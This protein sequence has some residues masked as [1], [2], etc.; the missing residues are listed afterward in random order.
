MPSLTPAQAALFEAASCAV[1]TTLRADGSPHSTVIWV[2][3]DG[4]AVSF[5]TLAGRA[6]QRHLADD[7]LLS[8]TIVK[9][10]YVWVTVSGR[11]TLSRDGAEQQLDRLAQ[12][13]LGEATYPWRGE[14]DERVTVTVAIERVDSFGL[15]E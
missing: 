8:I 12:K 9:E 4:E 11:A 1:L 6:K 5:N 7:P 14:G 10:P 13:Y 15:G 3:Y 2:D